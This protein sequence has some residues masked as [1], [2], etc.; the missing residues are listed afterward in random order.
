MRLLAGLPWDSN[1][2]LHLLAGLRIAGFA[3][4]VAIHDPVLLRPR[5]V[6]QGRRSRST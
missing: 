5:A 4:F 3:G 2:A 1:A 6:V